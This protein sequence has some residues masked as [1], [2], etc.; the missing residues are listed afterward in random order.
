MAVVMGTA[1]QRC[2]WPLVANRPNL[3]RGHLRQRLQPLLFP[4]S[5]RSV[6]GFLLRPFSRT[7]PLLP[8]REAPSLSNPALNKL[9]RRLQHTKTC[10]SAAFRCLATN[11]HSY[12]SRFITHHHHHPLPFCRISDHTWDS[13]HIRLGPRRLGP[14]D[15]FEWFVVRLLSASICTCSVE[16]EHPNQSHRHH[17]QCQVSPRPYRDIDHFLRIIDTFRR[18]LILTS[19]CVLSIS[20]HSPCSQSVILLRSPRSS[21]R[22]TFKQP[23]QTTRLSIRLSS[24][25]LNC[26]STVNIDIEKK[27]KRKEEFDTFSNTSLCFDCDLFVTVN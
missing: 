12:V 23:P 22:L 26:S 21:S 10:S 19:I 13:T 11:Y 20:S 7:A 9:S 27:K 1:V 6:C 18:Q 5:C 24:F 15:T 2:R 3:N 8:S 25:Y 17:R 4:P 16:R 14:T